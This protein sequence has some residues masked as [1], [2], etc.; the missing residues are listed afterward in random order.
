LPECEGKN[1]LLVVVDYFSKGAHFIPCT[2]EENAGS[3][4]RLFL[5]NV[6]KLHGTPRETISD[7]GTQFNNHFMERLYKL[8]GISPS[9]S[10]VYHPQTDGQTERINQ[11]LDDY[12]RFYV[13]HRQDDWVPLIAIAEFAYNHSVSTTTGYSPFYIWYGEHPLFTVGMPREDKVPLADELARKMAETCDEVKAM[14]EISKRRYKDQADKARMEPPPFKVGD[15]VWLSR[16]N[17]T[18]DRP[19]SKLDWRRLGPYE[20]LEKIGQNAF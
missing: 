11:V 14:I 12:L 15:K 2:N 17:I 9:F 19:T 4:A 18:T 13:S 10:T 6:W 5:D 20:I 1:A 16:E 3:T 7:R 8:L